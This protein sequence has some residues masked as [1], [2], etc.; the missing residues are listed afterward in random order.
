MSFSEP[1]V[2]NNM[3]SRVSNDEK[4]IAKQIKYLASAFL[5][6][7]TLCDASKDP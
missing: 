5:T 1:I 4:L 2:A 6:G 3:F 7:T